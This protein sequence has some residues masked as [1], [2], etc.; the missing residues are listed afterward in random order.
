MTPTEVRRHRKHYEHRGE[1]DRHYALLDR[2]IGFDHF[3]R[4]TT[5]DDQFPKDWRQFR[6]LQGTE[7]RVVM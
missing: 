5:L 6:V 4:E 2:K 1:D 3:K 7:N